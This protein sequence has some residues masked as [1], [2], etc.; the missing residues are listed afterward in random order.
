MLIVCVCVCVLW[1]DMHVRVC[2]FNVCYFLI[3]YTFYGVRMTYMVILTCTPVQYSWYI[4]LKP[5][6]FARVITMEIMY[7]WKHCSRDNA[8]VTVGYLF[9]VLTQRS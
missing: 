9:I 7:S 8:E 3:P 1:V 2:V 6:C 4:V 5:I